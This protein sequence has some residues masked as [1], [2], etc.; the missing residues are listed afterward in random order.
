MSKVFSKPKAPKPDR[1][2]LDAQ[3]RQ[4]LRAEQQARAEGMR[5]AAGRRARRTGGIRMLM[6]PDRQEGPAGQ[7]TK[8]GGGE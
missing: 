5:A 1:S 2:V 8:L 3:A 4:E 7:K 6:S